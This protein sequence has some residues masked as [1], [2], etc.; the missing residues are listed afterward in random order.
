MLHLVFGASQTP[1]RHWPHASS[2]LLLYM[3]FCVQTLPVRVSFSSF[4]FKLYCATSRL[5]CAF[6]FLSFYCVTLGAPLPLVAGR[7]LSVAGHGARITARRNTTRNRQA[8]CTLKNGASFFYCCSCSSLA[9]GEYK[10][11]AAPEAA[12]R[13]SHHLKKR[14]AP[15]YD[16][17]IRKK[18]KKNDAKRLLDVAP[19]SRL[20]NSS[21]HGH[22]HHNHHHQ[23]GND[24]KKK[25]IL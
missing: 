24:L 21:A 8:V 9:T 14:S 10:K 11:E 4:L 18:E 15:F 17:S 25:I 13:V 23:R 2:I 1:P 20:T 12:Q 19:V 3:D 16:R 6:L 7:F 5:T 22:H